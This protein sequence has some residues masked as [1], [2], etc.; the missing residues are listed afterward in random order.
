MMARRESWLGRRR[1]APASSRL[2]RKSAVGPGQPAHPAPVR[3]C[4]GD[5]PPIETRPETADTRQQLCHPDIS[6]GIGQPADPVVVED[7]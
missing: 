2:Q 6:R 7:E 1:R 4:R 3:R 5:I